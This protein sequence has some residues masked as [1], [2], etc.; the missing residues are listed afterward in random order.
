MNAAVLQGFLDTADA[1]AGRAALVI[2]GDE[3][4][5]FS[6]QI[7]S[8]VSAV[9]G[10][11]L[12]VPL[13]RG[14]AFPDDGSGELLTVH[15]ID[16]ANDD[17]VRVY[18][19]RRGTEA[20]VDDLIEFLNQPDSVVLGRQFADSR[21]LTIGDTLRLVTPIGVKS[22][23]VRGLLDPQGTARVL[24]G[25][26]VVMDVAAA[27]P[28][29][30]S[31]GQVNQID[32]VTGGGEDIEAVR[33]AILPLLP[34]GIRVE[35][36][37]V[38]KQVFRRALAAFQMMLS[39]FS[40]LA[41]MAGFVVCYGRLQGI[42]ETRTW[43]IGLLRAVGLRRVSV[44]GELLKEALLLGL[45]GVVVGVPLGIAIA[46]WSLPVLAQTTALNFS[47]PIPA[48]AKPPIGDAPF[49]GALVGIAAAL[50]AAL[51]PAARLARRSPVA[52][53]SML[54]RESPGSAT[55]SRAALLGF[56]ATL[57]ALIAAQTFLRLPALGLGTT[58]LMVVGAAALSGPMIRGLI[59]W[60]QG[61]SSYLSPT[62]RLVVAH[63]RRTPRGTALTVTTLG[64]G[65]GTVIMIG[66][67]GWSFEKS[68]V[69]M[70]TERYA[71]SLVVTSAFVRG[72]Y[73]SAPVTERLVRELA[74]V[75]GVAAVAGE[76]HRRIS[77]Q[78]S[79]VMLAAFD[80]SCFRGST[81]CNWRLHQP[82]D[83]ALDLVADGKAVVVSP[84]FAL[85]FGAKQ[86]DSVRLNSSSGDIELVIA[87]ITPG[88]PE[89]A[90][91]LS[92][93]V[94]LRLWDDPLITWAHVA[95]SDGVSPGVV[96]DRIRK[97]LAAKYRLRV[98]S[99]A[100]MI[101]YFAAQVR[102]A[103]SLQ[104]LLEIVTLFLVVVGVGDTL[105]AAV[106]ARRRQFGMMRA[107]GLHR[108]RLF[109]MV[110]LEGMAIGLLGVSLAVGLGVA[111]S[112][113]WVQVQFPALL[114][115]TL[116]QYVPLAFVVV[117]GTVTVALCLVG[118]FIPSIRAASLSP[119]AV[120]RGE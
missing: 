106:V 33:A 54:G 104:H 17:A 74:E 103:F 60:L 25:R 21:G 23:T 48:I 116:E 98:L 92:R 118:A 70:L 119:V 111:L 15:G 16:L 110:M 14:V 18:H 4:T 69:S 109:R 50:A 72:G 51:A 68:I 120:L 58:A 66:T 56:M 79:S 80:P 105:A 55:I 44:F 31:P 81:V 90:I 78:G 6:D 19:V 37:E 7:A 88:Q 11:S 86:G 87:A 42:F 53:L 39:A 83:G 73:E 12:A 2:A 76:Q 114:G 35:Q 49:F 52:A 91:I 3:G 30:G 61:S 64:I 10:V 20:L 43:E 63:L 99:S 75:P 96:A 65:L 112:T 89:S 46:R 84:S 8:L 102:E 22:F 100:E 36:P 1:T 71:A 38:R 24:K 40:L 82:I 5:S 97:G 85:Q 28:I 29:F 67:L 115:W 62:A 45:G 101:E 57:L 32:V 77:Y 13:V 93:D 107:I 117:A 59:G 113:F 47:L 95:T 27:Q 108:A 94:Y 26:L 41:L 9:P 34:S